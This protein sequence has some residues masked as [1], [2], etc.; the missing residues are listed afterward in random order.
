VLIENCRRKQST[1]YF[2]CVAAAS[3]GICAA[4][5]SRQR[6]EDDGTVLVLRPLTVDD[7]SEATTAHREL[8]PDGFEF[9]LGRD[10]CATWQDYLDRLERARRGVDLPPGRVPATFLGAEVDGRLVGRVSIRHELTSGLLEYGG[11]IGYGVR[12]AFR[13]R[14]YATEIL[15]QSLKRA[16]DL[17]VDRALLTCDDDNIASAAVI[18]RCGGVLENVTRAGP[19]GSLARRYW[20]MLKSET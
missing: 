8:L 18:E 16:A 20:I 12:P 11:H 7:E 1:A 19:H 14:G 17:G 5:L 10:E 3:I 4:W 13:R 9:L 15:R 6:T 2:T